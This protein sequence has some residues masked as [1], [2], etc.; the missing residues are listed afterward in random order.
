MPVSWCEQSLDMLNDA[1]VNVW[2]RE[3]EELFLRIV[4]QSKA[5]PGRRY[6]PA[7]DKASKAPMLDG[8]DVSTHIKE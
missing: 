2:D 5:H 7:T 6:L 3:L 1:P 8:K 4:A